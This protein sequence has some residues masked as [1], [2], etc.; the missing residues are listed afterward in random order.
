MSEN[1]LL[2]GIDATISRGVCERTD[3]DPKAKL[4][5]AWAGVVEATLYGGVRSG[6]VWKDHVFRA[7]VAGLLLHVGRDS[8]LGKRLTY[9]IGQLRKL[10][11]FILAAGSGLH[12]D[13]DSVIDDD[14]DRQ[15]PLG[16]MGWF[17]EWIEIYERAND[18][19]YRRATQLARELVEYCHANGITGTLHG[20]QIP[21]QGKT[22]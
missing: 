8:D 2:L 7:G 13:L 6:N 17:H 15:E 14:N 22:T 19:R 9:E 3:G 10:S 20:V 11:A 12:V 5:A 16:V 4:H 18:P 1:E 21:P